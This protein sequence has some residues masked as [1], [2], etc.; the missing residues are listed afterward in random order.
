MTDR[1]SSKPAV[2]NVV[3]TL[4]DLA[5]RD[6]PD[7][8]FTIVVPAEQVLLLPRHSDKLWRHDSD[9]RLGYYRV[10]VYRDCAVESFEIDEEVWLAPLISPGALSPAAATP[11]YV[12]DLFSGAITTR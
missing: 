10:H 2:Q 8:E 4:L 12:G 3:D 11:T 1:A 6:H 7:I 5:Q 9:G